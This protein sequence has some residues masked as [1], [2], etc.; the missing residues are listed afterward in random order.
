MCFKQIP[1]CVLTKFRKRNFVLSIDVSQIADI[2][3]KKNS[4][5][6]GLRKYLNFYFIRR[7]KYVSPKARDI[8]VFSNLLKKTK[9]KKY[10]NSEIC[11]SKKYVSKICSFNTKN[12][13]NGG[14]S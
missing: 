14:A 8:H 12:Y 5:H 11:S 10:A 2:L 9:R 6:R 4:F 1:K 7:L 3:K 13:L